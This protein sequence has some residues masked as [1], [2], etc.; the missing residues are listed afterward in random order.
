MQAG[1]CD[2]EKSPMHCLSLLTTADQAGT[3]DLA[4]LEGLEWFE[5]LRNK[6]WEVGNVGIKD[7]V[8]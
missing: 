5:Y 4:G 6:F 3:R 7:K 1:E 2:C 8:W